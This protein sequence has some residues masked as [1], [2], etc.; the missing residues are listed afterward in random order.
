[1]I[2]D[3]LLH[4]SLEIRQLVDKSTGGPIYTTAAKIHFKDIYKWGINKNKYALQM[5]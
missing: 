2:K 4:Q 5:L 3:L 1:M